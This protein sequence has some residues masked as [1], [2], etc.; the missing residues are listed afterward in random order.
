MP[1]SHRVHV[2]RPNDAMSAVKQRRGREDQENNH[3]TSK[4]CYRKYRATLVNDVPSGGYVHIIVPFVDE[5]VFRGCRFG[6]KIK[7]Q[8]T[9][10]RKLKAGS[11]IRL[12]VN[13]SGAAFY[14]NTNVALA[15]PEE[16]DAS[17]SKSA[18]D[19]TNSLGPPRKK[20][21]VSGV[22]GDDNSSK[23]VVKRKIEEATTLVK[24]ICKRILGWPAS[25][26]RQSTP[27]A[28]IVKS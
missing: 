11:S 25:A 14:T 15:F 12:D 3:S 27:P 23:A 1:R 20:A 19:G 21:N 22:P 7:F 4:P 18:A 6:Q 26:S 5:D 10:Q 9:S 13:V 17:A 28:I 24:A 8:N 16:P 2:Q